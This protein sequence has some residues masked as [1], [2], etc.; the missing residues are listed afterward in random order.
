MSVRQGPLLLTGVT[1]F[2]AVA[3][4]MVG[5]LVGDPCVYCSADV[6]RLLTGALASVG[7][8]LAAA[9]AAAGRRWWLRRH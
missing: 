1:F 3:G 8:V 5:R 4:I 9:L 7:F 2:A 6:D